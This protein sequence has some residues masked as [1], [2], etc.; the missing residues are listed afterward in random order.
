VGDVEQ[1]AGRGRAGDELVA[2]DIRWAEFEAEVHSAVDRAWL[3]ATRHSD[4]DSGARHAVE[5]PQG[6]RRHVRRHRPIAGRKD[7]G[8][9][10]LLPRGRVRG[11]A[12]HAAA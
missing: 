5:P 11:V 12:Q 9:D 1:G 8:E 3:T 6:R 10:A 7:G 4:L 2:L